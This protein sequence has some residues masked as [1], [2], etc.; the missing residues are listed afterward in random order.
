MARPGKSAAVLETEGKSH[1]TRAEL[2]TRKAAEQALLTGRTLREAPEVRT[3]E[4]AHREFLRVSRLLKKV[5]RNDA[6]Y[7][8]I[9]NRYCLLAA[10][11]AEAEAVKAEFRASREELRAEY[12][13]GSIGEEELSAAKYYRL[14][15]RM[16]QNILSVDRAVQQKRQMMLAI[17]KE[18]AMTI[19]SAG[20]SI[21][22]AAEPKK[23]PLLEALMGED[24]DD[25]G[26]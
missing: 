23:N 16:Q 13:S 24:E 8:S 25:E 3:N 17:E 15:E 14:L 19:V 4:I 1:R 11:C 26:E 6:L 5:G 10:E 21:P 2:K 22:K 18:C 9:I 12:R 20:R 7:E